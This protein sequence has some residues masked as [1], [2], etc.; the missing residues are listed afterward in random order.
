MSRILLEVCVDDAAGLEAARAGGADRIELCAALGLGGLTPS[1]GL[2]ALAARTGLPVMAMIRPRAGDFVWSPDERAAMLAEIEATRAAGL[3]GVVIG[4]SRPDGRLDLAV[5]E[6]QVAAAQGLDITLH[7]AIDLTPD[8][9][10]AMRQLAG[11]GIDRV[12]SS[13]GAQSALE[14]MARLQAMAAAAPD[15]VVM[16]GGGVSA[17][18]ANQFAGLPLREIHAS[19]SAPSPAPALAQV[20]AFGFQ[21]PGARATDAGQVRALRDRLDQI[22]ASRPA[23]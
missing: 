12:L 19:A 5:L 2:M 11:L 9:A 1:A 7:R 23:G 6:E 10:E 13:G 8:P 3:A 16:P 18:N 22:G 15:V 20:A 14:G 17:A 4:A 21:P